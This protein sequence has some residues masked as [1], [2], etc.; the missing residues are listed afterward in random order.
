MANHEGACDRRC[1]GCGKC[2]ECSKDTKC[3]GVKNEEGKRGDH[4]CDD[5]VD[6]DTRD[7]AVD[8]PANEEG[9]ECICAPAEFDES[10]TGEEN[11]DD[12]VV[13]NDDGSD[14]NAEE[15]D[16]DDGDDPR[17]SED[18][19]RDLEDGGPDEEDAVEP[20]QTSASAETGPVLAF[21][22]SPAH[23]LGFAAMMH[24][25]G[26]EG[27]LQITLD[28]LLEAQVDAFKDG[29]TPEPVTIGIK[30]VP[31]EQWDELTASTE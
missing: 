31:R 14:P 3:R 4:I 25:V 15:E 26:D 18:A 20:A 27:G 17:L 16:E 12:Y 22:V 5:T 7:H 2:M 6:S 8:C 23:A 29:E 19:L 13:F 21:E 30:L 24:E 10:E 28:L 1:D 11:P 9:Y